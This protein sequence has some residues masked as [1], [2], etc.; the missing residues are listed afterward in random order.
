ML[1]RGGVFVKAFFPDTFQDSLRQR[2]GPLSIEIKP[3]QWEDDD[4]LRL[5]KTRMMKFRD[6]T[7]AAWCDPGKGDLSPNARLIGAAQGTPGDLIRKGNELLRRIGQNERR[8]TA[9]DLDEIL[10]ALPPSS[11]EAEL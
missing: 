3:L 8:L 7:L 4:L 6:E 11:D 9:R 2:A 5:L 1:A 10:G